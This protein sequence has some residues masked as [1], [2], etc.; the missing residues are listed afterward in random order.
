MSVE[1]ATLTNED[2]ARRRIGAVAALAAGSLVGLQ[3]GPLID[4]PKAVLP[5]PVQELRQR[6]RQ[7]CSCSKQDHALGPVDIARSQRRID[8]NFDKLLP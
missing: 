3:P 2:A 7:R 8:S 4:R 5:A 6:S 1:A